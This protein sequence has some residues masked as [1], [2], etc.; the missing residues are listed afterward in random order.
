M[1][2]IVCGH[3]VIFR[4][5]EDAIRALG[6]SNVMKTNIDECVSYYSGNGRAS[7]KVMKLCAGGRLQ[8]SESVDGLIDLIECGNNYYCANNKHNRDILQRYGFTKE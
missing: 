3:Y 6:E 8:I 4:S 5:K 1:S 2:D 7:H